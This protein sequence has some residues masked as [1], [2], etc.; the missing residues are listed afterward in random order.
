MKVIETW[1][2]ETFLKVQSKTVH[3]KCLSPLK[4]KLLLAPG[5]AANLRDG[6]VDGKNNY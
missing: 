5:L 6:E 3:I 2:M 4:P 1:R